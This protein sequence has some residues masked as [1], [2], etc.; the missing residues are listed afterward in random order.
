[1]WASAEGKLEV[2]NALL[3]RPGILL[4]QA[5]NSGRTALAHASMNGHAPIVERLINAGAN[6]ALRDMGGQDCIHHALSNGHVNVV[7]SLLRL[8]VPLPD[9]FP[10]PLPDAGHFVCMA[11]LCFDNFMP[12]A[13]ADNPLRL[14][15]PGLLDDP[16]R[17]FSQFIN[18]AYPEDRSSIAGTLASWLRFQGIR[19]AVIVPLMRC[20]GEYVDGIA[21]FMTPEAENVNDR[22]RLVCC[23]STLGRLA[24]LAPGEEIAATYKNSGLSEAG[25][26]RL[27]Q[28]AIAQRDKLVALAEA[29]TAQSATS[30]LEQILPECVDRT[31]S[32][33]HVNVNALRTSLTDAGFVPPLANL[34]AKSWEAVLVQL[35]ATPA[36]TAQMV[37]VSDMVTYI[38]KRMEDDAPGLFARQISQRLDQPDF[39]GAWGATIGTR[40]AEGLF[41]LFDDQ[42]KQLRQY[43]KET[44]KGAYSANDANPGSS[45]YA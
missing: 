36:A 19:Q 27:A 43:G 13:S 38:Q 26:R 11:D 28:L 31:D 45:H 3:G 44:G 4:E 22:Q 14:P 41:A 32:R 24:V 15:A 33:L 10:L 40:S 42:C 2:V 8:G 39:L 20:L 34:L 9:P 23:A 6:S 29:A 17:F 37:F 5:N 12:A 18:K 1:M 16:D 25:V 30:M 21:L 7:E 35:A